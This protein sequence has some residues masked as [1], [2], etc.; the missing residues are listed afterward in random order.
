MVLTEPTPMFV[1]AL[2]NGQREDKEEEGHQ[3]VHYFA[4]GGG[5]RSSAISISVC[6]SVSVC[7]SSRIFHKYNPNSAML[8]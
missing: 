8:L 3:R 5:M 1:T 4:P 6:L 7:L 2:L